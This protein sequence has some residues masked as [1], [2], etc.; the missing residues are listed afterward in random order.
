MVWAKAAT[1]GPRVNSPPH[2]PTWH[3]TDLRHP[4]L[5]KQ[6]ACEQQPLRLPTNQN[7]GPRQVWY[8]E[9]EASYCGIKE[10][11]PPERNCPLC[12]R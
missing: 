11:A 12:F 4:S 6:R 10:A 1:C 5:E 7:A 2:S 3:D 8:I 9:L